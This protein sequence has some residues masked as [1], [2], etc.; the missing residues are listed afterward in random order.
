MSI[1]KKSFKKN[2]GLKCDISIRFQRMS[3]AHRFYTILSN[4][5]FIYFPSRP[6]SLEEEKEWL[7]KSEEAKRANKHWS[8]TILFGSSVIGG[9]GIRINQHRTY[10]GEI[11]YFLDEAY[12]GKG[13]VTRAVALVEAEGMKKLKLRRFEILMQPKNAASERVALKNGYKKEGRLRHILQMADGRLKD[14]Y[15]YAKI[16]R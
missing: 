1:G 13:I 9:I 10:I 6:K 5:N 7:K 16:I 12:W 4:P 3:D 14:A 11:G 8:Y 2:T 15:L